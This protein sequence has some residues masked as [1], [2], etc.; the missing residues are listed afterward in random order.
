MTVHDH[1]DARAARTCQPGGHREGTW[2]DPANW[3]G[4]DVTGLQ[5]AA[6]LVYQQYPPNYGASDYVSASAPGCHFTGGAG[7]NDP[8]HAMF[9][10]RQNG[11]IETYNGG[12]PSDPNA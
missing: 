10:R 8:S 3:A 7:W 1:Y 2:I 11:D 5:K 6:G 4:R 9:L 12:D